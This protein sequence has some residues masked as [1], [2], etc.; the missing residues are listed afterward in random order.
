MDCMRS[1]FGSGN[2]M[3]LIPIIAILGWVVVTGLKLYFNHRER[4]E[5]IRQNIDPDGKS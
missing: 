3:M 5:K 1:F 4:M 2:F